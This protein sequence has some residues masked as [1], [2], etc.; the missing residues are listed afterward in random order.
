MFADNYNNA[1]GGCFAL[2]C[3]VGMADG[4][5]RTVGDIVAGDIVATG[6]AAAPAARVRPSCIYIC[7][8]CI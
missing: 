5:A 3:A 1:T 2:H 7:P 8:S 4:S 6:D